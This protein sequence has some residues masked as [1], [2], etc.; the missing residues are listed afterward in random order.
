M[1]DSATST[2]S[3]GRSGSNGRFWRR[4]TRVSRNGSTVSQSKNAAKRLRAHEFSQRGTVVTRET[5]DVLQS[6]DPGERFVD[7]RVGTGKGESCRHPP[8][9]GRSGA[10]CAFA[11]YAA[12]PTLT[13][14]S[15][16][17]GASRT[18]VARNCCCSRH[19]RASASGR[20]RVETSAPDV[21][22]TDTSNWRLRASFRRG[23]LP[24]YCYT[25][26]ARGARHHDHF[27]SE[28]AAA[29]GTI[30]SLSL[31]LRRQR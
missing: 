5:A 30:G 18:W 4:L 19:L 20:G 31:R 28:A 29:S 22:N 27:A 24:S 3:S 2:V 12:I 8:G 1:M 26:P 21:S 11:R 9:A 25:V 15:S 16:T 17:S 10:R 7:G 14:G 6:M 13:G 23:A